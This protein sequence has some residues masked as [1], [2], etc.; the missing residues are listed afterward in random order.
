MYILFLEIIVLQFGNPCLIEFG[1]IQPAAATPLENIY[2]QLLGT[3]DVVPTG[4]L[5]SPLL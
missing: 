4:S 2:T 3:S 5:E 1:D